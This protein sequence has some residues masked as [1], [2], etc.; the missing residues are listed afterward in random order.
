MKK[1]LVIIPARKGS[2]RIE[3]KNLVKI[4]KKP[5]ICWTI[6][7]AKKIKTKNIDIIV[8]SDCDKVKKICIREKIYFLK[9]P[10]KISTDNTKM[11][12]VI[13]NTLQNL[14]ENYRYIILLQ[15][16]SPL[17]DKSLFT[18]SLKILNTQKKFDSLIHVAKNKTFTGTIENNIWK[19]SYKKN[20]R[21]QDIKYSFV[22]TGNL[23]I[24][25]SKLFEKKIKSPKKTY[26]L[27]SNHK[28]VDIDNPEDLLILKAYLKK[29]KNSLCF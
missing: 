24:Y 16:T 21:S 15:P 29:E 13:F 17:R 11:N 4:L 5:L 1:D 28:W 18:N 10:K 8:S 7:Y 27:T 14:K 26:A 2:K 22:S 12:Q 6:D 19:P 3:N 9:R 23:F 20:I 25:R